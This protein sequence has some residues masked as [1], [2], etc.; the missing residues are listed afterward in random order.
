M[1]ELLVREPPRANLGAPDPSR[2][3]E[4]FSLLLASFALAVLSFGCSSPVDPASFG[5]AE[6]RGTGSAGGGGSHGAGGAARTGGAT[7]MTGHIAA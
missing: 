3:T 7:T 5:S 6:S 2:A 1:F 4:R